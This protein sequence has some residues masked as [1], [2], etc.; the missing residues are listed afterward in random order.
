M[1]KLLSTALLG[2]LIMATTGCYAG[3]GVGPAYAPGFLYADYTYP[4][5]ANA[6]GQVGSK[7]GEAKVTSILGLVAT[8][9]ASIQTAAANGGITEVM[10][11]DTHISNIVGVYSV[12]TTIVTGE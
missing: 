8:G 3:S 12:T 4:A 11:V 5:Y 2:S 9:D 10:T 1:R 6:G 7:T